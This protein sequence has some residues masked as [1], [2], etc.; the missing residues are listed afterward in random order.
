MKKLLGRFTKALRSL[1]SSR[2]A[3][4]NAERGQ[5]LSVQPAF[6]PN[7][8]LERKLMGAAVDP[9]K[10]AEFQRLLLASDVYAA[11]P[12]PPPA[13]GMRDFAAGDELPLLTVRAPDESLVAA[14]FT[15][16]PRIVE[17]FGPGVGFIR[18]QGQALLEL[19]ATTGAFLNPASPYRVHWD[20]AGIAGVLGRPVTRTITKPTRVLLATPSA[21][22]SPLI[23]QLRFVLGSRSDVPDAWLA[24]AHWPENGEYSWYLDVRT[25]L[26]RGDVNGVL[27]EVFKG[28]PFEGLPLDMI[29]QEPGGPDGIGIRVAPAIA[30]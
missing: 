22:P 15:S 2:V 25:T 1:P 5:T 27:S 28:A 8:E 30:H 21:P 16:E 26:E 20:S 6:Q 17:V 4:T 3:D 29:V 18:M 10:R 7:N 24:L 14:I 12:Q 13:G 11:T 23:G 19:V 9:D